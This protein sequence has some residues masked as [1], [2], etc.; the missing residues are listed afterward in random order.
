MRRG[1]RKTRIPASSGAPDSMR[2]EIKWLLV[3]GPDLDVAAKISE[4][5]LL[6]VEPANACLGELVKVEDQVRVRVE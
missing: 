2:R 5:M 1:D 6:D 3:L 4:N